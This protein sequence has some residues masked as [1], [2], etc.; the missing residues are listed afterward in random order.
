MDFRKWLPS[1][2]QEWLK[3]KEKQ[4]GT[5]FH[6]DTDAEKELVNYISQGDITRALG[7]F[8]DNHKSVNAAIEEY[9]TA[10]HK[11]MLRPNKYR[12]GKDAYITEKLPRAWQK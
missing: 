8:E 1:T 9:E 12:K 10:T 7:L 2:I 11:V 5:I 4:D 3:T 6:T